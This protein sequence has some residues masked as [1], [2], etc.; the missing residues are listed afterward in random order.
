MRFLSALTLSFTASAGAFFSTVWA[1]D[2]GVFDFIRGAGRSVEMTRVGAFASPGLS[3]S[4]D[5]LISLQPSPATAAPDAAQSHRN[6]PNA[7]FEQAPGVTLRPSGVHVPPMLRRTPA[8]P[9]LPSDEPKKIAPLP[10]P[11]PASEPA[12]IAQQQPKGAPGRQTRPALEPATRSALGGPKAD[13]VPSGKSTIGSKKAT[14][15]R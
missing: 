4:V 9:V 3:A 5:F 10:A 8:D 13:A 14:T 2:H 15:Q 6:A 11:R 12:A 7:I 1:L